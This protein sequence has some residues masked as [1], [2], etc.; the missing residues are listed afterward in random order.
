MSYRWPTMPDTGAAGVAGAVGDIGAE[1]GKL[2]ETLNKIQAENQL[3]KF[4]AETAKIDNDLAYQLEQETDSTK[5]E[6]MVANADAMKER[7]VPSNGLA[8]RYARRSLEVQ[9]A[10]SHKLLLESMLRREK[11][12]QKT[13]EEAESK[14]A[15]EAVRLRAKTFATLDDAIDFIEESDLDTEDKTWLRTAENADRARAETDTKKA[16]TN[17]VDAESDKMVNGI[18]DGTFDI[19]TVLANP[20][21]KTTDKRT[22]LSDYQAFSI[23]TVPEESDPDAVERIKV[24]IDNYGIGKIDK[25]DARTSLKDNFK[26]LN[27]SDR[28]KYRN[29]IYAKQDAVYSQRRSDSRFFLKEKLLTEI[30]AL[31]GRT[32]KPGT[33][34]REQYENASLEMEN[35]LDEWRLSGKWPTPKDFHAELDVIVNKVKQPGYGIEPTPLPPLGTATKKTRLVANDPVVTRYLQPFNITGNEEEFVKTQMRDINSDLWYELTDAE[36][37]TVMNDMLRNPTDTTRGVRWNAEIGK[38]LK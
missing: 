18:I 33:K 37:I 15:V 35:K 27:T 9:K 29:E 31:G 2:G 32:W 25:T 19:N 23:A 28:T 30:T 21:I 1:I 38:K 26:F 17:M 7:L 34:E 16:Y 12:T 24:A 20:D 14:A 13:R 8:A 36:K 6:K 11:L 10:D 22:L 5:Y 3:A 4:T